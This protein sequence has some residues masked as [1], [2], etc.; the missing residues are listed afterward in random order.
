MKNKAWFRGLVRHRPPL[1][2]APGTAVRLTF[3]DTSRREWWKDKK[4]DK[5]EKERNE[6]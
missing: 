2:T 4:A 5:K 6:W 3:G 1:L